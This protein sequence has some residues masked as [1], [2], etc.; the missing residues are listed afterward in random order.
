M[1]AWCA[2]LDAVPPP[3]PRV[4]DQGRCSAPELPGDIASGLVDIIVS[5]AIDQLNGAA[6]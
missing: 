5:I 4:T 6:S 3:P 1:A 2:I